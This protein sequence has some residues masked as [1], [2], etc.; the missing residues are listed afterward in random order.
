VGGGVGIAPCY[1]QAK[2]LKEAGNRVITIMGA[3]NRDL[4]FW[5]DKFTEISDELIVTTDD[6]S[7]GMKGLVIEPLREILKSREI[8]LVIAI[9]PLIMMK[10]VV[11][12]TEGNTDYPKVETMVS[13]NTI[14]IDGTG[15]CGGCRFLTKEGEIY[16]ACVDGPDVDGHIVNFENLLERG[17]RYKNQEKKALKN[18]EHECRSLKKYKMKNLKLKEKGAEQ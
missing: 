4:H 10:S 16:F 18:Y 17:K 15:M 11:E 7:M 5:I 9:G 12:L 13:L 2:E 3:R 8:S 14:M 1:P 6:G